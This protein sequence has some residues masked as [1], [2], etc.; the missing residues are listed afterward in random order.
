MVVRGEIEAV[1]WEIVAIKAMDSD[2][3]RRKLLL[4]VVTI[5]ANYMKMVEQIVARIAVLKQ[6]ISIL[7]VTQMNIPPVR[8]PLF[9]CLI[10]FE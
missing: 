1:V 7:A 2:H 10:E 9:F 6:R 3:S 8:F 5:V 4:E